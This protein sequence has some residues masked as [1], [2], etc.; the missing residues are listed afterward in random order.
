MATSRKQMRSWLAEMTDDNREA[1]WAALLEAVNGDTTRRG[2][3][4][5]GRDVHINFPDANGRA[6]A[7]KILLDQAYGRP[8][9]TI[10]VEHSTKP[11]ADLTDQELEAWANSTPAPPAP[12][13]ST[14]TNHQPPEGDPNQSTL[15][16]RARDPIT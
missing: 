12:T 6:N 2:R 1:I 4:T 7:A 11:L 10:E 15:Y 8:K 9:E 14:S 16:Y 3:C 13:T 5:C